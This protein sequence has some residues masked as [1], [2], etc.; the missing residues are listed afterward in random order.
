MDPTKGELLHFFFD[1]KPPGE[2]GSHKLDACALCSKP[3]TR[4][5][6][7]FMYKGWHTPLQRGEPLRADA[8]WCRLQTPS[9]VKVAAVATQLPRGF[10]RV[11]EGKSVHG[12]LLINHI[13]WGFVWVL[14]RRLQDLPSKMAKTNEEESLD[15][16]ALHWATVGEGSQAQCNQQGNQPCSIRKILRTSYRGNL[17]FSLYPKTHY[18]DF[19]LS[20]LNSDKLS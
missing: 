12:E 13:W 3:L 1:A 6:D 11:E 10:L 2:Q 8:L 17:F 19:R 15:V 9:R 4:K 16:S 20:L 14:M 18:V 7:I 5:N